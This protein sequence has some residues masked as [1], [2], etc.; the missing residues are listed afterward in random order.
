LWP[1]LGLVL[2]ALGQKSDAIVF[3][4]FDPWLAMGN[5]TPAPGMYWTVV[6]VWWFYY[7]NALLFCFNMLLPMYPMDC[8]RVVHALLWRKMGH[9]K[10]TTIVV[11]VG[12]VTAVVLLVVAVKTSS[13]QLLGIAL[14]GAAMCYMERRQLAL[15]ADDM[16]A[17][18]YN[19]DE[20]FK[21]LPAED[22]KER[23]T[24]RRKREKQEQ[25]DQQELDRILSKIAASGMG[26][27]NKAEK[28]WLER[29]SEKRRGG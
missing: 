12:F 22:D 19:F 3:N 23:A 17:F 1:V 21:G 7:V 13:L 10:A 25:D 15:T 28:R 11:N 16:S 24:A 14:F 18:G 20:G 5:L 9:R 8:G 26:S 29:A 2:V 27:L 4:P 6:T